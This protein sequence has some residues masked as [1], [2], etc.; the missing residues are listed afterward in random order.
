MMDAAL[1]K[2]ITSRQRKALVA[3]AGKAN[4]QAVSV[5]ARTKEQQGAIDRRKALYEA[6]FAAAREN[7]GRV[8]FAR[9]DA[10]V[11]QVGIEEAVRLIETFGEGALMEALAAEYWASQ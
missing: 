2:W 1:S 9:A 8:T 3:G 6:C 5:T 11:E 7:R 10:L 4:G